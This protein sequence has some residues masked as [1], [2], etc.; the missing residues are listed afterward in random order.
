[1][2]KEGDPRRQMGRG[3]SCLRAHFLGPGTWVEGF[4]GRVGKQSSRLEEQPLPSSLPG[5][6]LLRWEPQAVLPAVSSPFTLLHSRPP[7]AA[8][9]HPLLCPQLAARGPHPQALPLWCP[10]TCVS[11]PVPDA[12]ISLFPG[13]DAAPAPRPRPDKA[14]SLPLLGYPTTRCPF[15]PRAQLPNGPWTCLPI[16]YRPTAPGHQFPS[17]VPITCLSCGLPVSSETL[18][19]LSLVHSLDR[20]PSF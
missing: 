1:M 16:E 8:C 5:Q 9:G 4:P 11:H 2:G 18:L 15:G 19:P 6:A 13:I 20:G 14:S 7:E 12:V 17:S 10:S 3:G